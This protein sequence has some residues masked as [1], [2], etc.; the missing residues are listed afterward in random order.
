MHLVTTC[1]E[2]YGDGTELPLPLPEELEAIYHSSWLVLGPF[3]DRVWQPTQSSKDYRHA[4]HG[5]NLEGAESKNFSAPIP[6]DVVN[7]HPHQ[8]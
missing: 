2:F 4:S 7:C 1:L 6:N 3:Q 5:R 8:G